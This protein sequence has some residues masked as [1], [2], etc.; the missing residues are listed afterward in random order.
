MEEEAAVALNPASIPAILTAGVAAHGNKIVLRKKDR[1]IWKSTTWAELNDQARA[2]GL[3]LQAVGFGA[4]DIA[5]VLAETRPEW[6]QID[7]GIL[8][9]GGVSG[10]IHPDQDSDFLAQALQDSRCRVL[11]VENEEQLDKALTV[12][13]RCPALRRIVIIDMKGLRDFADPMCVSLQSFAARGGDANGWNASIAAITSDQPA[14]LSLPPTGASRV[15]THGD[16][17]GLI[18]NARSLLAISAGDERL[19]LLPM[20]HVMERVLGLYLS[21]ATGVISNY[22]ENP[23]TVIE[24]LQELQPMML[25]T[26][27]NIWQLLHMRIS[28]AA[29]GATPLQRMLYNWAIGVAANDGAL[30]PLARFCV[31]R[32]VRQE[33]GLRRLRVAYIGAAVLA[34]D[35]QRWAKALGIA[36]QRIDGQ[37]T[38]GVTLDARAQSLMAEALSS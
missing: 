35:I 28:Q 2:V 27:A 10:G 33:I 23:D 21:L 3:G 22:L 34:P 29:A 18:D 11:F 16:A 20:C 6:V 38:R 13:D 4:G 36:I 26:D 30:A 7:L 5:C 15:L 17:L 31:L 25:A 37:T 14:V 1:G 24:N 12:R 9:C 32:A 19:A 8:G